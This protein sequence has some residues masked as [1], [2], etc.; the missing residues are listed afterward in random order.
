MGRRARRARRLQRLDPALRGER[1]MVVNVNKAGEG[2]S[3]EGGQT[4]P[5]TTPGKQHNAARIVA[6][7]RT[8]ELF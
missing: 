3:V 5:E 8:C 4:G 7:I 1:G 2:R 6:A